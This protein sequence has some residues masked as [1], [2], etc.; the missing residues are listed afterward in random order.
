MVGWRP[1]GTT[2]IVASP[3]ANSGL[4]SIAGGGAEDAELQRAAGDAVRIHMGATLT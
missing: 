3:H 1:A 4:P 2:D